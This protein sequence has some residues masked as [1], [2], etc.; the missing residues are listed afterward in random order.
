MEQCGL[1]IAHYLGEILSVVRYFCDFSVF[2][3]QISFQGDI[4]GA[5]QV[6]RVPDH[7]LEP[8]QRLLELGHFL[9][10]GRLCSVHQGDLKV[11]EEN[12][13]GIANI[14]AEQLNIRN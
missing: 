14:F 6:T 4:F 11:G 5:G 3:V 7:I 13:I 12:Y 8:T 1:P 10:R 9:C 2:L